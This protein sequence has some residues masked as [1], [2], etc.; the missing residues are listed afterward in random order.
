MQHIE[1]L[2]R[3]T[4]WY[5]WIMCITTVVPLLIFLPALLW[6]V[7][8]ALLT[9]NGGDLFRILFG[10]LVGDISDVIALGFKCYII[11]LFWKRIP[12]QLDAAGRRMTNRYDRIRRMEKRLQRADVDCGAP[13]NVEPFALYG[14]ARADVAWIRR[15]VWLFILWYGLSCVMSAGG[16]LLQWIA[17]DGAA[18]AFDLGIGALDLMLFAWI[19]TT[20]FDEVRLLETTVWEQLQ[21]IRA[22][23][24]KFNHNRIDMD[25]I[26][27]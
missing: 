24:I 5:L 10:E 16:A 11:Y 20:L 6:S 4:K 2:R 8:G 3:M 14:R 9:G 7:A 12:Q 21:R 27:V 1:K 23:E 25:E 22:L 17:G 19:T 26:I 18:G 13:E 15:A